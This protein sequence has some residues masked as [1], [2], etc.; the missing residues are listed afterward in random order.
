MPTTTAAHRRNDAERDATGST[1]RRLADSKINAAENKII[2]GAADAPMT[3]RRKA[4]SSDTGRLR[5][6]SKNANPAI[7]SAMDTGS[8][9]SPTASSDVLTPSGTNHSS[10]TGAL[11]RR[12]MA[13]VAAAVTKY[14][15]DTNAVMDSALIPNIL[16]QPA[17]RYDCR[18]G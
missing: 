1:R 9:R 16:S 3:I 17:S 18:G 2:L 10:Q 8:D 11:C 5:P 4:S 12:R 7:V 14:I 13:I 6:H 15:S